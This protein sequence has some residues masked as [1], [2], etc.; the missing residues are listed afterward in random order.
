MLNEKQ[1]VDFW[2]Y[3]QR[4][5]GFTVVQKA[6]AVEMDA[7]A[8]TLDMMGIQDKGTFMKRYTTT[9]GMKVYVPFTRGKGNQKALLNQIMTCVHE[10]E[11][12]IQYTRNPVQFMGNYAISSAGRSHYEAEAYLTNMEI[13]YHFTG[14]VLVPGTLANKLKAYGVG[15]AD[16][17]VTRKQLMIASK[18]IGNGDVISNVSKKAIKYLKR[19]KIKI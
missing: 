10:T 6:G 2:K 13:Y 4:E 7:I 17:R 16:I 11:H 9:L 3:M 8:W 12:V 5:Y 15:P 14:R 1:V 18:V 19:N